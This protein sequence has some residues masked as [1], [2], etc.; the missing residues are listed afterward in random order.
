MATCVAWPRATGLTNDRNGHAT[1]VIRPDHRQ[2]PIGEHRRRERHGEDQHGNHYARAITAPRVRVIEI[3]RHAGPPQARS[4]RRD[5]VAPEL[6][7][8]RK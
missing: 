1:V 7:T 6:T 4:N 3:P 5:T 2:G 8:D